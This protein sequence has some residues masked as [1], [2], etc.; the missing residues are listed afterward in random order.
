MARFNR[1]Q[2]DRR[3]C[4]TCKEWK[5]LDQFTEIHRR[6]R[7]EHMQAC[8][9]CDARRTKQYREALR[10]RVIEFYS[11]GTMQ[12]AHCGESRFPVLDLDHTNGDGKEHRPIKGMG[13]YRA[14]I[15]AD[16]EKDR[17]RY[18]VLCRNCNWMARWEK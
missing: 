4:A 9:E 11:D 6:G 8:K 14:Y 17:S 2:G 10:H 18:R 7:S 1:T 13:Q 3:I 15:E 5:P 16:K 12:C